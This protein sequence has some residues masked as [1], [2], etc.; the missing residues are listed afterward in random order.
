MK[1]CLLTILDN[2]VS[3]RFS[4]SFHGEKNGSNKS[5]IFRRVVTSPRLIN[6]ITLLSVVN[7]IFSNSAPTVCSFLVT[8]SLFLIVD[9]P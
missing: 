1:V 5:S 6:T 7:E 9:G 4:S 3:Y 8:A 2:K